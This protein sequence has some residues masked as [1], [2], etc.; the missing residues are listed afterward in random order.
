[1]SVIKGQP[2]YLSCELSK[3]RDVVWKKDGKELK[4]APGKVA[5]NVIGLQRTVT[6][7][8]SNDD[9]AGVYTC[10]CENLKTQ[11]NVKIIGMRIDAFKLMNFNVY[12]SRTLISFFIYR[13]NQRLVDET[14]EGSAC[15]TQGHSYF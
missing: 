6:I 5:I 1:M 8:D 13:N 12:V 2:M 10:E 4:P 11:V 3:D 7:H 15:E 9:D 14:F